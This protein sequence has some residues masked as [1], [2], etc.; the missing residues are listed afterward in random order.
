MPED[1]A[2][3]KNNLPIPLTRFIGREK[4][5]A[6]V[7]R[8]LDP[9]GFRAS[10]PKG[11]G[12]R[13]LT[14]TG[15]GGAG[16]TRLALQVADDLLAA[17]PDGVWLIELA[18]LADPALVPHSVASIFDLRQA[19]Q[20]TA[21]D[22]L[23]NFLHAKNGL[24][25]LDNCE[26]VIHACAQLVET[27]LTS[28]PDLKILATSREGLNI[29]GE[30]TFRVPPLALPHLQQLPPLESFAQFEAIRLFIG[31]AR[32]ARPDFELT[33]AN[34][35]AIAQICARLDGMPLALELAA[36]R[37]KTL[38][39]EQIAARLDDSFRLLT[40]GS[41]T[42]LPRQQTLRAA[43]DWSYDLLSAQEQ[44][45]LNRVSVFAGG[46]T[47]EAA[48][49]ICADV[50]TRRQDDAE[51][52]IIASE[53]FDLLSRL[54]D[55]SLVLAE[56]RG[57]AT[58]YRIL[59]TIRQYVWE[60]LVELGERENVQNRHLEYFVNLAEEAEPK[61]RGAEQGRWLNRLGAELDNFRVAL[62]WSTSTQKIQMGL[63]LGGA[64]WD[65][66]G[67]R[68]LWTEV[69][70]RLVSLLKGNEGKTLTRAN[71]L[72]VAA[73]M[74]SRSGYANEVRP[75]FEESIQ[76]LRDLGEEGKHWLGHTLARYAWANLDR[77]LVH[78]CALAKESIQT[79]RQAGDLFCLASS[80]F[81]LGLVMRRLS[82]YA[83]SRS[84]LEGSAALY[85][86]MRNM[87][88]YAQVLNNLGMI[89]YFEKNLPQAK[90]YIERALSIHQEMGDKFGAATS[91]PALGDIARR[92]GN[93]TEASALLQKNLSV[94]RDMGQAHQLLVLDLY[95]LGMLELTRGNLGE[96]NNYLKEG[97][98]QARKG[99]LRYYLPS[100][101]DALGYLATVV[102]LPERA[103]RLF[104]AAELLREQLGTPM[105]PVYRDDCEKY[106]PRTR[107]QLDAAAFNAAWATGQAMTVE[108]A[109]EFALAEI[110]IPDMPDAPALSPRQAAK[111]KFGGLTAREREVAALIAQ[112]KSNREIA[113]MLVL[114]ERTIEGHVGNIL[115]KLGFSA[116]TQIAAWAVEI[117]LFQSNKQS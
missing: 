32:D 117:G 2:P 25:V 16:K 30:I 104:G 1:K 61:L 115:D 38:A 49:A 4:E 95:Y 73:E 18:S 55:K 36:A 76:I 96:S 33:N 109:I 66:W 45:A 80:L 98:V 57:G 37:V 65:F 29:A 64:L 62:D 102:Q 8:L 81:S 75:L 99:D 48:E 89:D 11:L 27:L 92:Q 31:R 79:S 3:V 17:F 88:M 83:T 52:E 112:G 78:A 106:L 69:Y 71:A 116:R 97:I 56:T 58:R 67:K 39:V 43:M 59:E 111:E 63:R 87:H 77:D 113:E 54:V 23:K 90:D 13:L 110:K 14:L 82:D 103:A 21:I 35:P 5:I 12:T 28:C 101:M 41:R 44:I 40:G 9:S 70:E 53:V 114:S 46:W 86:E 100:L 34:A 93:Y 22:L 50:V 68:A 24:L 51:N 107:A 84:A 7:K 105:P 94:H 6:E 19:G 85:K 26:H 20:V 47:L 108:Q 60:K 15:A 72:R 91:R 42:A 10:D 74:A